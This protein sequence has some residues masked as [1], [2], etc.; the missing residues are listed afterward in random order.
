MIL[1]QF[2]KVKQ[3]NGEKGI[4]FE[5]NVKG[6]QQ[7]KAKQKEQLGGFNFCKT[8]GFLV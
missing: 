4:S 8:R 5:S 6:K 2:I 3:S 7:L 1:L